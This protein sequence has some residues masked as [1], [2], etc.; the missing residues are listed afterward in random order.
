MVRSLLD[1]IFCDLPRIFTGYAMDFAAVFLWISVDFGSPVS[2]IFHVP[3]AIT[4]DFSESPIHT[5]GLT[6]LRPS[7]WTESRVLLNC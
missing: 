6:L 7:Y 2:S 1:F 5:C 4:P 3:V